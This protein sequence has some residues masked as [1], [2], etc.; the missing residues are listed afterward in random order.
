MIVV[1]HDIDTM[2]ASDYILDIGPGA[3]KARRGINCGGNGTGN[4]EK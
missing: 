2:M 4:N 3:G 1:E